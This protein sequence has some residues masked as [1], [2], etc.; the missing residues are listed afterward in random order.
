MRDAEVWTFDR[1]DRL[2][3][4]PVTVLGNPRVVDV[5]GG[6]AVAFDGVDDAL[7]VDA[8]PLAGAA[9]FTWEVIFRPDRGGAREQRF[10]HLQENNADT[11]LLFET[12]L[13]GDSWFLDSYA[14][15]GAIG[16]AL[17]RP[18]RLHPLG[19]WY[20]VAMVYD[21]KQFRNYVNGQL[22]GSAD[23]VLKPQGEGRSS[24]GVRINLRDYFKGAIRLSRFSR[25]ALDVSEFLNASLGG[26]EAAYGNGRTA[27]TP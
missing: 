22:E 8:H 14:H 9:T 2:G 10:F 19:K 16:K 21:G 27:R 11:R 4:R 15:S 18:D 24:A 6:K 3:K 25:R 26:G 12:R 1:L 23:L 7:M 17:I 20:H 5:P 13:T